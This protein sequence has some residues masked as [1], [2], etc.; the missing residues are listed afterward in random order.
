MFKPAI[1]F[2]HVAFV[3]DSIPSTQPA[4]D[5]NIDEAE[6]ATEILL[7]E[8]S[9]NS[10]ATPPLSASNNLLPPAATINTAS[11]SMSQVVYESA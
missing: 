9:I 2:Q 4:N 8:T 1:Y 10:L 7:K 11:K 3:M 5:P 6:V